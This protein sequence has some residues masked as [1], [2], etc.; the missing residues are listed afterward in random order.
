VIRHVVVWRLKD[1]NALTR[2]SP[3]WEALQQCVTAM[4]TGVP[5]LLKIDLGLDQSRTAD[6]GDVIL[7]S[8]FESWAAL[9]GYQ[10]HPLHDDFKKLLGPLR[11]ERRLMD[12]EI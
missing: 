1:F 11:T 10:V 8:E 2:R 3:Q 12:Y 9:D 4:R 6:S 7:F 5:G